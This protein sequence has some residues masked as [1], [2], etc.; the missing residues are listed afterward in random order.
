MS[1]ITGILG[2]VKSCDLVDDPEYIDVNLLPPEMMALGI[3]KQPSGTV[4]PLVDGTKIITDV[5]YL[6]F[7]RPAQLEAE[8]ISSDEYLEQIEKWVEAQEC[9]ENYP[10]IGYR[11]FGVGIT[12][13]A[14]MMERTDED[15]VYQ[16]AISITYMKGD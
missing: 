15:A 5:Y 7:K 6:L 13:T 12:N 16:L 11:V 10:E 4:E 2:W 14:Y 8:R 1:I 9:E 3:Y